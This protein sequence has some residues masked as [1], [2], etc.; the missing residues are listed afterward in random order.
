M[1]DAI[2]T[3]PIPGEPLACGSPS[4]GGRRGRFAL[5]GF[6]AGP[7]NRLVEPAVRGMLAEPSV[8][9]NPLVLYGPSGTGK[10]HLARGLAAAWR[11]RFPRGRVVYASAVDFARELADAIDSQAVEEFRSGY[12]D[13]T[14]AVFEDVGNLAGKPAAQEELICTLDALVG[15]GAQV[16]VTA[17]AAP[18]ELAGLL[19]ALQSRLSAGLTVPLAPPGA[20]ARAAILRQWATQL[21]VRLADSALALLA[22]GLAGTVPEL[23]GAVVQLETP[24]RH[25]RRTIDLPTVRQFVADRDCRRQPELREIA[26][27]TARYFA[28]KL[29]DLRGP[30]RRRPVVVARGVAVYLCR[31]LTRQS[32]LTIG[33]YFGK[34]DHTT[35]MHACRKTECLV[36]SNPE[37]RQA[38]HRLQQELG[39]C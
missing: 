36:G 9:Y 37:I 26:L 27:G 24:A 32:L 1:S 35:I 6:L 8:R 28:L 7:E 22:E 34:R 20:A 31:L 13:A 30:S 16:L 38:T 12:R 3:I 18:A 25:D 15:Q 33:C 29:A 11:D 19:P 10:S 23:L 14:L 5:S 39:K 2:V 17:W 21:D 4:R